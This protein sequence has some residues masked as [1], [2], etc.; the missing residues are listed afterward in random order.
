M[1]NFAIFGN[2][3]TPW[4]NNNSWTIVPFVAGGSSDNLEVTTANASAVIH[5][6]KRIAKLSLFFNFDR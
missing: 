4:A 2:N 6:R 5:K 1:A 3:E